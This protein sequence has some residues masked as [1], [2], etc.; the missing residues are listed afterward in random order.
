MSKSTASQNK[1]ALDQFILLPVSRPMISYL[2][3]KASQVIRCGPSTPVPSDMNKGLPPTPPTTPPPDTEASAPAQP[4]LPSLEAFIT[5]LVTRSHVQVP[6]LMSSLVY[7]SRLQSRLPPVAK[8]MR[9]TVHR[10]FLASLILAA[11]NLN[12]ASPKNKYWARYSAVKGFEGFGFSVT[13]VNLMEKQLLFLLDWDLRIN[14]Q[15]LY[16]HLE[17]FLAPIRLELQTRAERSTYRKHSA[18]PYQEEEETQRASSTEQSQQQEQPRQQSSS[19]PYQL[20]SN[21]STLSLQQTYSH[22]PQTYIPSPASTAAN[23]T[24]TRPRA[25]HHTRR[26]PSGHPYQLTRLRSIS[27]PS[28]G[29]LPALT[30][31]TSNT[32]TPGGMSSRSSSISPPPSSL[33]SA[34]PMSY[35]SRDISIAS[36]QD[37]TCANISSTSASQTTAKSWEMVNVVEQADG[38]YAHNRD[39]M[40]SYP[41]S[42]M[43]MQQQQQ[44][45]LEKQEALSM[46]MPVPTPSSM[47]MMQ[48]KPS[49]KAKLMGGSAG[50]LLSRLM[51]RGPAAASQVQHIHAIEIY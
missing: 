27:P 38:Y 16:T 25:H 26:Q 9:C 36:S 44:L 20:Y 2:A 1:A 7:L 13:E 15:D 39:R 37:I 5:A 18:T 48:E 29:D 17:P 30:H 41:E 12:D 35:H 21:P 10:I 23:N 22:S 34:T 45:Q 46:A 24:P 42:L 47:N 19:T 50:G 33:R 43:A 40:G 31:S 11:K 6:T 14:P 51:G 49:K 3:Q 4:S 32:S 28:M 8:G